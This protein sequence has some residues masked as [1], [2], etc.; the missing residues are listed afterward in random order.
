MAEIIIQACQSARIYVARVTDIGH[1]STKPSL[2]Q[3]IARAI[4]WAIHQRVDIIYLG[5]GLKWSESDPGDLQRLKHSLFEANARKVPLITPTI[6][7]DIGTSLPSDLRDLVLQ[8][9]PARKSSGIQLNWESDEQ[10]YDFMVPGEITLNGEQG[11]AYGGSIAAAFATG[12]AATLKLAAK[13]S[14]SQIE[15][16]EAFE[17]LSNRTRTRFVFLDEFKI[18]EDEQ[19]TFKN[20]MRFFFKGKY[21][22]ND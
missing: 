3:N 11:V 20:L 21:K 9:A 13:L 12:L 8:I 16:R 22:D 1:G 5:V 19:E 15:T 10:D 7:K 6:E 2:I 17:I 18:G 14:D 4:E